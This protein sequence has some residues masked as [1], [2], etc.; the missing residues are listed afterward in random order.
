M[1]AFPA[2]PSR[3]VGRP[4]K[5]G[6][7]GPP[8]RKKS[9]EASKGGPPWGPPFG[10]AFGSFWA[11]ILPVVPRG[12]SWQAAIY[13]QTHNW[14]D[15]EAAASG[16]PLLRLNM[17][18]TSVPLVPAALRGVVMRGWRHLHFAR[19][20][21]F[22]A[23][24]AQSRTNLTYVAFVSDDAELN[25]QLPQ[26][27]IG[28]HSIFLQRDFAQLF[29]N[30]PDTVFLIRNASGW[31]TAE[32]LAEIYRVL[33]TVLRQLRPDHAYLLVMDCAPQH[34]DA[35]LLFRLRGHGIYPLLVPAKLTWLLQPL[36]VYI[37]RIFKELLR[38]RFHDAFALEHG[39]VTVHFFLPILYQVI[40][41]TIQRP[42]P[43]VFYK[44]GLDA[45]QTRVSG[46]IRA[47]L[48]QDAIEAAPNTR[49]TQDQIVAICP[50]GRPL[51]ERWF[52]PLPKA[53]GLLA[54]PAPRAPRPAL[55]PPAPPPE[56]LVP[57]GPLEHRYFTRNQRR[58]LE[59]RQ[60]TQERP[61]ASASSGLLRIRRPEPK[62]SPAA[63]PK[64]MPALPPGAPPM[65]ST[66]TMRPPLPPVPPAPRPPAPTPPPP[67]PPKPS[68]A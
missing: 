18:E 43:D 22:P 7:D 48:E 24:R 47:H 3:P 26:F 32:A 12:I 46:Y 8:P 62:A 9:Q 55:P 56:I 41:E 37:F 59:E 15:A 61:A 57:A 44:V 60:E 14:F 52:G 17:D 16:K 45:Q 30:T 11:L 35:A 38:R 28:R 51:L 53:G 10:A 64:P 31:A 5:G 2:P 1:Q 40:A 13:W 58:R 66:P 36:D 21:R 33:G 19:Q 54:L 25:R 67:I 29:E 20:G 34:M 6:Q 23:T 39:P 27:V 49:P 68:S 50:R 65:T 4:P 63:W 42:W